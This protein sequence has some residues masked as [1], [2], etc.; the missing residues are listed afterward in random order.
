MVTMADVARLSG[1]SVATVSHVINDT[2]PVSVRTRAA[3]LEAIRSTGYVQNTIARS[4]KT[5]RTNSIGLATSAISN[6]YFADVMGAIE[7]EAGRRGFTLLLSDTHDD[8]D[9][10]LRVVRALVERR[11]DGVILAPSP[12]ACDG[13]LAHLA[14]QR[15]PTVL[16]DR[17]ASAA[18]DQV[19]VTNA[20]ALAELVGHLAGNGHRRIG[21]VAGLEGLTTS[22]ER[23]DGYRRGLSAAGLP[24]DPELVVNGGSEAIRAQAAVRELLHAHDPPT[25]IVVGNNHMT[26]GVL[27]GLAEEGIRVPEDVAF[28]AFDDFEWADLFH[29][30]LT[31]VAQPS[32]ELG[33]RAMELM[34]TRLAQPELPP[35][36]VRLEPAFIHRDSC[37]CR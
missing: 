15:T 8:P 6:P 5:A 37:G 18:F 25:G 28:V 3:V 11:V 13:A 30:R 23:L 29:P 14:A 33:R 27:R 36:T 32:V 1:V 22:I 34:A 16:I 12:G 2:R 24:E 19:G 26:I 35:R 9:Q 17:L 31:V 7:T 21:Y 10:E 4:L 20:E